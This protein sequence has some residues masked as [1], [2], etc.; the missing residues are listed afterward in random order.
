MTFHGHVDEAAKTR[1]LHR[2][3]VMALPSVKEGWGLAVTEAAAL[4]VPTVAFREAGGV[5]ES[6]I[7]GRTGHLVDDEREFVETL[8]RVLGDRPHRTQLGA[9]ASAHSRTFTWLATGRRFHD[10]LTSLVSRQHNPDPRLSA[11]V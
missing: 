7:D 10:L 8:A 5:V 4:G 6:I 3:W 1:I 2:A 9:A 11:R